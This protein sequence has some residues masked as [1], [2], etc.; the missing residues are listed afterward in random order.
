[1]TFLNT[2]LEE[3][4][5]IFKKDGIETYSEEE[6][7]EKLSIRRS[8]FQELFTEKTDLLKK[9]LAHELYNREQANKQALA[10]ISDP[11]QGIMYLL[12]DGILYLSQMSPKYLVEMQR[13][14][15][16][17]WVIY[18]NYIN[19]HYYYQT[20][21]ILN[22]GI[23]KGFF[24]K[25]INIKLVSKIII[26]QINLLFNTAVFPP[27]QFDIVEVF[28]SILLYYLRGLC[29]ETGGKIAD[30]MFLKYRL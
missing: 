9:A 6:I 3:A 14:Y 17:V 18:M 12:Q 29:T 7:I 24:R 30:E 10:T 8:T 25:D 15:P 2:I 23:I 22:A 26:E 28:R 5:T 13:Y 4:Q 11:I 27:D 20:S 19:S 16:S 21:E 1:M